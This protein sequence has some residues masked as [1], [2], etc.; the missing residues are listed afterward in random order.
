M[1]APADGDLPRHHA[2][3]AMAKRIVPAWS[4]GAVFAW[5]DFNLCRLRAPIILALLFSA[6]NE[7]TAINV[8][9]AVIARRASPVAVAH[10]GEPFAHRTTARGTWECT[11]PHPACGAAGVRYGG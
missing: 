2:A 9:A 8:A 11:L 6:V 7:A 3:S 1:A 10:G 5:D 4:P